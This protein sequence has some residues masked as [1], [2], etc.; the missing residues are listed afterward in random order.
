M[1][2]LKERL[3]RL[4]KSEAAPEPKQE[5]AP[6]GEWDAVGARMEH[7]D[8]GSFVLRRRVYE[9]NYRHGHYG[10][11][12]LFGQAGAL[13]IFQEPA[14][15]AARRKKTPRSAG[16]GPNAVPLKHHEQLLF[17]DTETTGLGIGAGNVPFMIGIGY[18]EGD[19]FVVEQMFI[20]NPGEE[21][22]MLGY[23]KD[24][25]EK[26]THLVSYNGKS[27]DWPILKNR[28]ILNRMK[29]QTEPAA[30]LDFLY[31]SRG[32]W[33]HTMPSCRLG[34]VEEE[35]LGVIRHND[36]PGSLAPTLYFQYLAERDPSLVQGV[37]VHNELDILSLAALAVHFS[38]ALQGKIDPE[39]LTPEELFRMGVWLD[40]LGHCRQADV[41][42]DFLLQYG[43][44]DTA[45]YWLPLAQMYK[46]RG[47]GS[48][49]IDLWERYIDE[50]GNRATAS[51]EPFIELAMHYEHAEKDYRKALYFAE[52]GLNKAWKRKTL[53][54]AGT[55]EEQDRQDKQME[56]IQKRID[57][58]KKK[59]ATAGKKPAAR[60]PEYAMDGLLS[61]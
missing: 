48:R 4:K 30:H 10:L 22:A 5:M 35:R 11:S 25:L 8:W 21:I 3:Q 41:V 37:F 33:K 56:D 60:R 16:A 36:V 31:P 52:E 17:F 34:A 44:G 54:R 50:R 47:L 19:R 13:Q 53:K 14:G 23:L 57:R 27:F 2:G 28:Y 7:G 38:L 43:A 59:A 20:R 15:S 18:Y 32:L 26:H 12:E 55:R 29:L 51:I 40:K 9:A 6:G 49:S 39:T 24:K 1:S 61:M 45:E 46:K 42:I 58:L